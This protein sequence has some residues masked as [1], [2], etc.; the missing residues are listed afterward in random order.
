MNVL[1]VNPAHP[2]SY[3]SLEHLLPFVGRRSLMAPLALITVAALLPDHWQC[4]LID[5]EIEPL[6]DEDILAADVVM[7]TGMI[8]QRASLHEVLGRCRRLGVRS[9][10]G[11]PYATAMHEDREAAD[12]LVLG[13]GEEIVPRLAA[14]LAAGRAQPI[15]REGEK[16]DIRTSPVPRFDLVR[17]DAYHYMALQFSRGCPYQCEFCDI[18]TLYGRTPRTKTSAQLVAELGAIHATG[19]RGSAMFVDDNFIGN[20]KRASEVLPEIAAWRERTAAPLDFFTEASLDLADHPA[21]IEQMTDAGFTAAF[22]GIE[23]P[24]LESLRETGKV[25]NLRGDMVERLERLRTAGIDVWGG[26]VLGFDNDGPDIFDRM[27]EFVQR[28]GV[29]YATLSLLMALPGTALYQRLAREGRLLP[30]HVTGDNQAFSN[31]VT[32]LPMETLVEGYIRVLE[33][34]YDPAMYFERC[35][36]HLSKWQAPAGLPSIR[37]MDGLRVVARSMRSIGLQSDYRREYWRFLGWVARHHPSKLGLAVAQTCAGHHYITFTRDEVV[38]R[39]R[40]D[41]ARHSSFEAGALQPE[42]RMSGGG[43]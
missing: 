25:Q 20:R 34:I 26:F 24:S 4:R 19:F 38:P 13:E 22:I 32:V 28:S 40:A 41:L 43:N 15:Y 6:R 29:A 23:T 3:W 14:D 42:A 39:L 18:T 31:I 7:L 2:A 33:T 21:L 10:V 17:H 35:R 8:V 27:I 9:V 1:L 16:P 12:H 11:G 37:L 36:I 5:L 30:D